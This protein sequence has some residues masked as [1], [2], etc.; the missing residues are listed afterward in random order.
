MPK[1]QYENRVF[2]KTNLLE[3]TIDEDDLLSFLVKMDIGDDGEPKY[4][5]DELARLVIR[6]LPEYVFAWHEG[7]DLNDAMAKVGEAAQRLYETDPYKTMKA[8]YL[9]G[10]DD[11]ETVT[12]V[13]KFEENNRG[14]F[15]E[16]L[17]HL[18]L[19]DFKGTESLMSK[20][21]FS[22]ARNVAAH[23]FDAVHYIPATKQL[24]LGESKL[25]ST[26]NS[27]L[28]NLVS[29]LR[30]HLTRDYMHDQ[31]VVIQKN[32]KTQTNPDK[33]EWIKR[34]SKNTRLADMIDGLNLAMLCIYPHDVYQKLLE[35]RLTEEQ[36]VEYHKTNIR[37]LKD[38][39]DRLNTC[40]VKD[41]INIV[42]LLFPVM[43]KK[44]FVKRLHQKL[45]I[46]QQM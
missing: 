37:N 28:T 18:L 42:L 26:S 17:L 15:G 40:P 8:H 44:D 25:Y 6:T 43:D 31:F 14:E 34:L 23:G 12:A 39:F 41:R 5:T 7:I 3:V 19:R 27:G 20:V 10:K 11:D 35:K 29:D 33:E 16:L 4:P 21:Y 1:K 24:W 32:L 45:W 38:T 30:E 36:G 2:D 22:D 9:D 46:A 13:K